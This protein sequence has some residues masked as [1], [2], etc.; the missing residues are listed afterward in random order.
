MELSNNGLLTDTAWAAA[1]P[2]SAASSGGEPQL[3]CRFAI[4]RIR[5]FG[6]A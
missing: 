5:I 3:R 1:Q 6:F 2:S 4:S